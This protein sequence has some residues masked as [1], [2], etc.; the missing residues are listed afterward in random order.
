MLLNYRPMIETDYPI[1]AQ[2]YRQG[3]DSGMATFETEVPSWDVFNKKYLGHSRLVALADE[4]I[5][6]WATLSGV[7]KRAVYRGVA[8]VSVYVAEASRG[9]GLGES[10][11]R[12]LVKSSE[13]NKIWTLQAVIF[14]QNQSSII[15]HQRNDF[16][17]VGRREKIAC[18]NNQWQDT[19]LFERRSQL[20]Q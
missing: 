20:V 1:V 6:A 9:Q 17:L 15:I 4:K 18:L 16:R 7:S 2:I 14:P 19:L 11:L 12:A 8:E 10:L 13:K 3:I 5:I